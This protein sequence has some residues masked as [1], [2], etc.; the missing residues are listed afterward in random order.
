MK[1]DPSNALARIDND[2][3]LLVMLIGV[4]IKECPKYI[5]K[6]QTACDDQNMSALGDAAHNVKGASA[7]I[8]FD[9]CTKLA[10]SL[11]V[12][13]RQS[14]V[15]SISSFQDSTDNLIN[16]LNGGSALLT[17]WVDANQ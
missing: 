4:F 13:C 8:G 1:Y 17:E 11:E 6:L 15:K 10:E 14:G 3:G 7:A 12:S 16:V 2:K 5:E 9:A